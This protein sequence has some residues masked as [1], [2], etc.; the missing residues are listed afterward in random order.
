MK[1]NVLL[2]RNVLCSKNVKCILEGDDC[3]MQVSNVNAIN[4][5]GHELD[6]HFNELHEVLL[7]YEKRF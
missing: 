6:G 4:N 5:D 2:G 3:R 1:N 7:N